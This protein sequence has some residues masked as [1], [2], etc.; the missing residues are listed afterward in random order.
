MEVYTG[1]SKVILK[2]ESGPYTKTVFKFIDDINTVNA[3]VRGSRHRRTWSSY[4]AGF[5][6]HGTSETYEGNTSE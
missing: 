2:D 4:V 1:G 3:R 6:V 5:Q